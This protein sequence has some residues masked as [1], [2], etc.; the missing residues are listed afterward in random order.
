MYWHGLRGTVDSSLGLLTDTVVRLRDRKLRYA[1]TTYLSTTILGMQ[2]EVLSNR[3]TVRHYFLG[4]Y[5]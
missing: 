3:T 4:L 2:R 5:I 1:A